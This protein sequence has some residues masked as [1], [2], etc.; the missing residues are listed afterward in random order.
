MISIEKE[1]LI[2]RAGNRIIL[3]VFI[4]GILTLILLPFLIGFLLVP[5]LIY[6]FVLMGNPKMVEKKFISQQNCLYCGR[7]FFIEK[8]DIENALI[9]DCP[10]CKNRLFF[11][12]KKLCRP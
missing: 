12:D 1:P 4:C 9:F 2:K 6:G 11:K 8:H 7:E 10:F 3:G 5:F